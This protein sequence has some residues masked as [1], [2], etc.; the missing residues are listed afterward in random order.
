MGLFN[1]KPDWEGLQML[2]DDTKMLDLEKET[3]RWVTGLNKPGNP[4]KHTAIWNTTTE[5]WGHLKAAFQNRTSNV[6]YAR[7]L[8][9]MK[10]YDLP[11]MPKT[12]KAT[13]RN[14]RQIDADI[15]MI[16]KRIEQATKDGHLMLVID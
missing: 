6:R 12:V 16:K 14:I 8:Q 4:Y 2:I 11:G 15:L 1:R 5:Y 10:K 13:I 9:G 3:G 7:K